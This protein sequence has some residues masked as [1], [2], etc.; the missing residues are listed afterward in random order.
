MMNIQCAIYGEIFG[1]RHMGESV[2]D[3]STRHAF[4][5]SDRGIVMKQESIKLALKGRK[6]GGEFHDSQFKIKW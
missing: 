1:Q 3:Y 2:R 4:S 6:P 5:I